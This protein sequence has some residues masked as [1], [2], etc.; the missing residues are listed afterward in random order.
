[1]LHTLIQLSRL[2]IRWSKRPKKAA[3]EVKAKR[4]V[5]IIG[6]EKAPVNACEL[7]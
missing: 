3:A 1:M 4:V 7:M 5:G 2:L 6:M